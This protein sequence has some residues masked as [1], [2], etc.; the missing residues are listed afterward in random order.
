[1]KHAFLT[2]KHMSQINFSYF[3]PSFYFFQLWARES[4]SFNPYNLPAFRV[5][6]IREREL[7]RNSE[8]ATGKRFLRRPKTLDAKQ[9]TTLQP[10]L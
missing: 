9:R 10:A 4:M 7:I 1:M 3:C 6:A 8:A 2:L 5:I